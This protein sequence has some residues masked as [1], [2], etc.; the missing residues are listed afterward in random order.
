MGVKTQELALDFGPEQPKTE[1]P[2][3]QAVV[4]QPEPDM[5]QPQPVAEPRSEPNANPE[6][7]PESQPEPE[8]PRPFADEGWLEIEYS[9][10][11]ITGRDAYRVF[12][13][14]VEMI[15]PGKVKQKANDFCVGQYATLRISDSGVEVQPVKNL[16]VMTR[17]IKEIAKN[18]GVSLEARIVKE[19]VEAAQARDV[20]VL[21]I[22]TNPT[23][24]DIR[25]S[26]GI[27]VDYSEQEGNDGETFHAADLIA[28]ETDLI[29]PP[30]RPKN[31]ADNHNQL[32]VDIYGGLSFSSSGDE[33]NR[34]FRAV[35][36]YI[37][38]ERL[39]KAAMLTVNEGWGYKQYVM[40]E[41][42][43]GRTEQ[44]AVGKYW[45]YDNLTYGKMEGYLRNMLG[46][47]KIQS[48]INGREVKPIN[49]D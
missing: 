27:R 42:L 18:V 37:G 22:V 40:K 10:K 33:V 32:N 41:W 43:R 47:F 23:A 2:A 45:L 26:L 20:I 28:Y 36:V 34:T 29:Q 30:V 17:R 6:P 7:E 48:S 38:L 8:R 5:Q 44:V 39:H 12:E 14:V 25:M 35:L 3:L 16:W 4:P 11:L 49:N 13:K 24:Q 21:T 46:Y 1:K 9:G 31:V 19:P 15:G